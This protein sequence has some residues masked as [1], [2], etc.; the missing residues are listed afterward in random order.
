MKHG[1]GKKIFRDDE[2]QNNQRKQR[3][4]CMVSASPDASD[5]QINSY[6]IYEL[7]ALQLK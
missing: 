7:S 1:I 5:Q 2:T 3:G 6:I 4:M